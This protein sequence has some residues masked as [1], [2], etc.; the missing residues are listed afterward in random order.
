MH[1]ALVDL[2]VAPWV[3]VPSTAFQPC[4]ASALI[5]SMLYMPF[6]TFGAEGG[7]KQAIYTLARVAHCSAI[8]AKALFALR[9]G[10]NNCAVS[11]GQG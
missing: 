9:M 4:I 5:T 10:Q 8:S 7:L 11:P 6:N 2:M 3:L 1:C